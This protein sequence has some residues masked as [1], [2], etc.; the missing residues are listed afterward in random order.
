VGKDAGVVALVNGDGCWRESG[1]RMLLHCG[2]EEELMRAAAGDLLLVTTTDGGHGHKQQWR[3][4]R[5]RWGSRAR[6]EA[7]A[8]ANTRSAS[9]TRSKRMRRDGESGQRGTYGGGGAYRAV[10]P[11][12]SRDP[13]SWRLAWGATDLESPAPGTNEMGMEVP[14]VAAP[15]PLLLEWFGG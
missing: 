10:A 1:Q 7:S 9:T 15:P 13:G 4:R 3:R 12:P 8:T 5:I 14:A 11:P 2:A 6:G